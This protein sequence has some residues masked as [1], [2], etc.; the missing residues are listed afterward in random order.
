MKEKVLN[1]R[2]YLGGFSRSPNRI[3]FS[4]DFLF[5]YFSFGCSLIMATCIDL[6]RHRSE[7]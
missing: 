3:R 1:L 6:R 7:I 4:W 5:F 2:N